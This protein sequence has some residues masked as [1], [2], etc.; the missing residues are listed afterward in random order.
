MRLYHWLLEK[1]WYPRLRQIDLDIL[2]PSCKER[3]ADLEDAHATFAFHALQ[4]KAWLVL[5]EPVILTYV[6]GLK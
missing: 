1:Y 3:A 6:D 5:G 2:W 4:D